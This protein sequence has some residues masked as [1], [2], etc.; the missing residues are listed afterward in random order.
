[1]LRPNLISGDFGEGFEIPK[2]DPL[3]IDEIKISNGNDLQANF[4]NLSVFG[5][6]NF[7]LLNLE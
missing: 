5:P 1:M 3:I 6:S 7:K 2:L 4:K